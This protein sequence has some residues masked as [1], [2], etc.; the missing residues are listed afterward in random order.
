[1]KT[2]KKR[3]EKLEARV[4]CGDKLKIRTSAASA[5]RK[6]GRLDNGESSRRIGPEEVKPCIQSYDLLL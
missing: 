2:E 1:M 4:G 5:C 3:L 6:K